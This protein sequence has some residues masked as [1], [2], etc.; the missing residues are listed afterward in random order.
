VLA[1]DPALTAR[2]DGGE[3]LPTQ[4]I[5]VVLGERGVPAAAKL[6]QHPA[7]LIEIDNRDLPA[8]MTQLFERGIRRVFV[9]GG[10][11]IA[12]AFV[13]AGL[14][15]EYLIYLGPML[16]GGGKLAL[17]NVGVVGIHDARAL[18]ITSVERL[19]DDV[20]VVARPKEGQ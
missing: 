18:R 15:D 5:A 12:S 9:E 10:P 7:G 13:T 3:L 17:G 19:G 16:L 8:A 6:R 4:P 20:L 1:D 14:V 11:T 2:G